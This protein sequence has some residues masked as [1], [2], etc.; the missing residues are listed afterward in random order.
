M[1]N[2]IGIQLRPDAQTEGGFVC[3]N[4]S[5]RAKSVKRLSILDWYHI[6]RMH[7]HWTMFQA[8]RYALWL[9]R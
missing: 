4:E 2:A 1:E 9:S 6:L 5:A 7:Y 8:I 3:R